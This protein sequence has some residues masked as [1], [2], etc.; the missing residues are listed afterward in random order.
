MRVLLPMSE[1]SVWTWQ[2]LPW[3]RGALSRIPADS[4]KSKIRQINLF[5]TEQLAY[6]LKK[7]DAVQEG[8]GTLLDHSMIAYGS[9]NSDG[10]SHNHD[11]LPIL[12]AGSG[13]GTI[14]PGRHIRFDQETPI[15]NLWVSMLNRMDVDVAKLGDS[16]GEL[17]GLL[18]DA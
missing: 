6:F 8:D 16:T 11:N 2:R 3:Q 13:C 7:L 12:V 14:K 1:H 17:P 9:G 18:S 15:S 10:N 5:H 4:Q